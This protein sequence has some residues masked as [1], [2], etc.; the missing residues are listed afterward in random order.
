[1]CGIFQT[2]KMCVIVLHTLR[3]I[4]AWC[5][6]QRSWQ[7]RRQMEKNYIS[8]ECIFETL[9]EGNCKFSRKTLGNFPSY[10]GEKDHFSTRIFEYIWIWRTYRLITTLSQQVW[11]HAYLRINRRNFVVC[12]TYIEYIAHMERENEAQSCDIKNKM[13]LWNNRCDTMF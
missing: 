7:C 9:G 3:A 10:S 13:K 6:F 8:Q 11:R 12:E 2:P 5:V 1:M 4:D